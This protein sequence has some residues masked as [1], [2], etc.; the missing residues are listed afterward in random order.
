M[1][2]NKDL[3]GMKTN[4]MHWWTATSDHSQVK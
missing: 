2:C 1:S 3:K 4:K